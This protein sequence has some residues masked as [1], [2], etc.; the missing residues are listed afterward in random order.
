MTSASIERVFTDDYFPQGRA[1]ALVHTMARITERCSDTLHLAASE[2]ALRA[3]ATAATFGRQSA[4]A[5]VGAGCSRAI[6]RSFFV[7]GVWEII[8]AD[9]LGHGTEASIIS[10]AVGSVRESVSLPI[11]KSL[12]TLIVNC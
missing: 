6:K 3:A 2:G 12:L 4:R 9:N 7:K 1:T 11:D 8:Q 10:A 5:C